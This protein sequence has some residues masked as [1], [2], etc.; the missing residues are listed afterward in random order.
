MESCAILLYKEGRVLLQLR[1][2]NAPTAPNKWSFFGG[3]IEDET[4]EQAVVRE[5]EEELSYKL[6]SPEKFLVRKFNHDYFEREHIFYEEIN[7][8]EIKELKQR[9]GKDMAWFSEGEIENIDIV[10][11]KKL[12]LKLFFNF[13]NN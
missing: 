4:P 1:D 12:A 5:T 3:G 2:Q 8:E 11:E 6:K 10:L 9:E 7:S 13:I